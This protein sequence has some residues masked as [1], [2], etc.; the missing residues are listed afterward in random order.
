MNQLGSK[1]A[2]SVRQAKTQQTQEPAVPAAVEEEVVV[3]AAAPSEDD[4]P[5]PLFSSRRVWPD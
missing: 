5:L 2:N 1:L 4:T 3:Q